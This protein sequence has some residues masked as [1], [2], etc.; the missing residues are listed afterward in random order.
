M[1]PG[2][3]PNKSPDGILT[4]HGANYFLI[5]IRIL[6]IILSVCKLLRPGFPESP[7]ESLLHGI[8]GL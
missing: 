8:K 6:C 7:V 1:A 3:D 2:M 4:S 5:M